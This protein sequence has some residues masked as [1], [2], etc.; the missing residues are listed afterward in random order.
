MIFETEWEDMF[1]EN[2]EASYKKSLQ[3]AKVVHK[4]PKEVYIFCDICMT[5]TPKKM[6][7][8]APCM[9]V[10]LCRSCAENMLDKKC[11]VCANEINLKELSY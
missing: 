4:I 7:I 8:C 9:H 3:E 2:N 11:D 10:K 1:P 6:Y 5:T